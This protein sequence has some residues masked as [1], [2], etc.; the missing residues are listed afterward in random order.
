[1]PR[2]FRKL[3]ILHKM[4]TAYGTAPTPAPAAP[5]AI[6]GKNVSFTPLEAGEIDRGLLLPSV[7]GDALDW[8]VAGIGLANAKMLCRHFKNDFAAMRAASG[9]RPAISVVWSRRCSTARLP[10][11][12]PSSR[13]SGSPAGCESARRGWCSSTAGPS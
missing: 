12:A 13:C 6:I 4:E 5:D 9:P 8:I 7:H 2:I 3:A 11:R 1:M 10:G